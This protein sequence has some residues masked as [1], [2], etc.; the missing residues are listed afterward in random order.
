M[1]DATLDARGLTCPMPVLKARKALRGMSAGATLAV[2]AT[3]PG[4][5]RDFVALC[6]ATGYELLENREGDGVFH[7]LIRRTA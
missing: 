4:A 6:E 2:L 5:T 1:A 3:D 7:F